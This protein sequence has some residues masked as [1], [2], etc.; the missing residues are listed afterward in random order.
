MMLSILFASC[1]MTFRRAG[2]CRAGEVSV[3]C[4][5]PLV[6]FEAVLSHGELD[7]MQAGLFDV[8]VDFVGLAAVLGFCSLHALPAPRVLG[9]APL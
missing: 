6:E 1:A 9:L 8:Q 4:H 2:A 5:Q 7:R 3:F